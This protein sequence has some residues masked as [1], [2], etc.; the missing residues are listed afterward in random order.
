MSEIEEGLLRG[1]KQNQAYKKRFGD[2]EMKIRALRNKNNELQKQC[3]N[4]LANDIRKAIN[5]QS[6][7]VSA[8]I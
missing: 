2:C 5:E 3:D 1:K 6:K 7:F 4:D 8:E